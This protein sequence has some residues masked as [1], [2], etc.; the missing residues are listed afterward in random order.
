MINNAFPQ[1]QMHNSFG[2]VDT[3]WMRTYASGLFAQDDESYD[4]AV[5]DSGNTYV[6]GNVY[7]L[8][9]GQD[10][11]T[12]KYDRSGN[13]VWVKTYNG[14]GNS[15]DDVRAIAIDKWNNIYVTGGSYD[16]SGNSQFCTIKYNSAGDQLWVKQF[17][18]VP[19][20]Q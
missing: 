7:N 3:A 12:I 10:F 4:I 1:T 15:E 2:S 11:C 19:K 16:L 9:N 13:Q 5:D 6:T 14:P 18:V 8:Q 20:T 17:R